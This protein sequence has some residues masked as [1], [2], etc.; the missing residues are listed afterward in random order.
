M[1]VT[2]RRAVT[3]VVAAAVLALGAAIGSSGPAV[4]GTNWDGIVTANP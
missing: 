3:L 4:A 1:R 2:L